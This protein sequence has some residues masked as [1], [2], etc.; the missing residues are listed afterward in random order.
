MLCGVWHEICDS[1]EDNR[2]AVLLTAIDYSKAF[3]RMDFSKCLRSIADLGASSG[4]LEVLGTFLMNRKM[5]V[6]VEDSWS[7]PRPVNGGVSQG[8]LLGVI[9]FNASTDSLESGPGVHDRDMRAGGY[10]CGRRTRIRRHRSESIATEEPPANIIACSTPRL[11]TNSAL[12]GFGTPSGRD[13][14]I[15]NNISR[16]GLDFTFLLLET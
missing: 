8:S 9:L 12:R 7:N 11:N 6:R 4:V 14:R 5:T 3:N 10:T 16:R 2:A 1:L 13:L 15:R